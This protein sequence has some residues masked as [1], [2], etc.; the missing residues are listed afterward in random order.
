LPRRHD[1]INPRPRQSA[2][3]TNEIILQWAARQ[4]QSKSLFTGS[5]G[6][7]M[8]LFNASVIIK[9]LR[10][11]RGLTQEQLAE[12]ICT[13]QTIY[14]IESGK[15]KPTWS[16]FQGIML[17]LGVDPKLYYNDIASDDDVYVQSKRDEC[18]KYV[19]VWDWESL[20]TEVDKMA[21]D[22]RFAEGEGRKVYLR[23]ISCL[24]NEGTYQDNQLALKC[25]LEEIKMYRPDFELDK[26]LDYHLSVAE[27]M[28]INSMAI[29]YQYLEGQ[30]KAIEILQMLHMIFERDYEKNIRDDVLSKHFWTN[31]NNLCFRYKQTGRYEECITIA[32]KGIALYNG[33]L[34]TLSYM[35]CIYFKAFSLMKLGNKTEGEPLYKKFLLYTFIFDGY[36]HLDRWQRD[37]FEQEFGYRLDLSL[38]WDWEKE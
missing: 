34:H 23:A 13:K 4:N 28:V 37:E 1:K 10:T 12:G 2:G 20:K 30:D 11:A 21:Q 33:N 35:F 25:Q 22:K 15:R 29:T 17:K 18:A 8:A 6:I 36:A 24:H 5:G 19:S 9:E 3:K 31:L 16:V 32:D 38:D 27:I 26:I 7:S 14:N